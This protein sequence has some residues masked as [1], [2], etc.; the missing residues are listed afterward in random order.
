MCYPVTC[1]LDPSSTCSIHATVLLLQCRV[2]SHPS[3]DAT[4]CFQLRRCLLPRFDASL[5]DST[6]SAKSMTCQGLDSNSLSS[7]PPSQPPELRQTRLRV[8]N[9]RCRL[10]AHSGISG[11]HELRAA[12]RKQRSFLARFAEKRLCGKASLAMRPCLA[13]RR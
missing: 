1:P 2:C 3:G 10:A 12:K 9:I 11:Q 4:P 13:M 8:D 7:W 5:S 6:S